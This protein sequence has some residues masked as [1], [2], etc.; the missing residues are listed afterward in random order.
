MKRICIKSASRA[1]FI[2]CLIFSNP[3]SAETK[4]ITRVDDPIIME[5]VDFAPLFGAPMESLSLMI[6]N[7]GAWSPVPFQIDQKKPDGEYAFTGGPMA[8]KDPDPN[9]DANDELVFMI[10][11]T[12]DSAGGEGWPDGAKEGVEIEVIDPRDGRKGWAYLL[13]FQGNAPWSDADYIKIEYIPDK[14][15]DRV[16]TPWSVTEKDSAKSYPDYMARINP[17]GSMGPN[18]LDRFKI[19]EEII[20]PSL[21]LSWNFNIEDMIVNKNVA[22]TDGAVRA[23]YQ[24]RFELQ[25]T[26]FLTVEV[27]SYT[28][29]SYFANQSIIP[30]VYEQ[31]RVSGIQAFISSAMM[32]IIPEDRMDVY[33]DFTP[34]VY[35]AHVF[36]NVHP[37]NKDV[38]ADGKMSEAEKA[39]DLTART[40]WVASDSD[41]GDVLFR[42][43][44]PDIFNDSTV[45]LFYKDDK[46]LKDPP[47]SDPGL[48]AIGYSLYSVSKIFSD[49]DVATGMVINLYVYYK[50]EFGEGEV[51]KILDILDHPVKLKISPVPSLD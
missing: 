35:G 16:T 45:G 4:T 36:S 21:N 11:D 20:I 3:V 48:C 41:Q 26:T 46:N 47:E 8:S 7:G 17:D 28:V 38:V 39:L 27:P 29:S 10:K 50:P 19:R 40:D 51:E 44:L 23:M 34:A 43:E 13:G 32:R 37:R 5:C 22:W 25:V 18:L 30:I 24:S 2:V 1:G 6:L 49:P 31:P 9:L 12:G 33:I 15:R 14:N 42:G